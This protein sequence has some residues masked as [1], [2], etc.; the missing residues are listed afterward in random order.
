M[1]SKNYAYIFKDKPYMFQSVFHTLEAEIA[2]NYPDKKQ[3]E[4]FLLL[5]NHLKVKK[6]RNAFVF[7]LLNKS[8]TISTRIKNVSPHIQ[9]LLCFKWPTTNKVQIKKKQVRKAA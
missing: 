4:I 3:D 1:K 7:S 2:E 9:S 5:A 6:Q 8:V